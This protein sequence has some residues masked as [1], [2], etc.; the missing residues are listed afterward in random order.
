MKFRLPVQAYSSDEDE[1]GEEEEDH[2]EGRGTEDLSGL[3]SELHSQMADLSDGLS[4]EDPEAEP[5]PEVEETNAEACEACEAA[6]L[7]IGEPEKAPECVDLETL[8][9]PPGRSAAEESAKFQQDIPIEV[10]S[11]D[12]CLM[13]EIPPSLPASSEE[14]ITI[15]ARPTKTTFQPENPTAS[16][17][18]SFC[19]FLCMC[20]PTFVADFSQPSN[21]AVTNINKDSNACSS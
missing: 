6:S 21:E 13:M 5:A 10:S 15:P 4:T 9:S 7:E 16:L 14:P 3:L 17:L 1:D 2:Y 20:A 8:E 11:Q 18:P 12:S 19:N